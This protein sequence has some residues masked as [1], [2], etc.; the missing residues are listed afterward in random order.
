MRFLFAHVTSQNPQYPKKPFLEL[1][2]IN[3]LIITTRM[4]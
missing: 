2:S 3:A 4:F 1:D